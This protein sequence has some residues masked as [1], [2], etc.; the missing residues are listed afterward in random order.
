M[1]IKTLQIN[2]Y[3][4]CMFFEAWEVPY[5]ASPK[6]GPPDICEGPTILLQPIRLTITGKKFQRKFRRKVA[7]K[8]L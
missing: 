7:E 2:C 8:A 3:I 6:F 4:F 5:K 1:S